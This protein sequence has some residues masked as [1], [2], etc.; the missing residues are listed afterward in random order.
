[1]PIH[2]LSKHGNGKVLTYNYRPNEQCGSM[3]E[4]S[5]EQGEFSNELQVSHECGK[6]HS[7]VTYV[8]S[9]QD[10]VKQLVGNI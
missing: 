9:R 8:H 3:H 1:M 10:A 6:E 7:T 4:R 2:G 5:A